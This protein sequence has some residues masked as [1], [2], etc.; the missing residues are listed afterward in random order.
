MNITPSQKTALAIVTRAELANSVLCRTWM[1]NRVYN[2]YGRTHYV[3]NYVA[4]NSLLDAG[5][6]EW[7]R[8]EIFGAYLRRTE[9]GRQINLD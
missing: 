8:D 6:I 9:A 5:L 7:R 2:R 4:A 3:I 1:R